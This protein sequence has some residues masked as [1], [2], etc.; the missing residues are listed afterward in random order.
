LEDSEAAVLLTQERLKRLL[1]PCEAKVI[2]LDTD[3]EAI[4]KQSEKNPPGQATSENIAYVIYTSG[5]T[6]KPK[7]VLVQHNSLINYTENICAEFAVGP[8]DRALQFASIAFDAAAE[9]IYPSLTRGATL[10]LR[11]DAMI[12]SAPVF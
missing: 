1:P 3:W 6:G 8:G 10:V 11:S 2:S 4:D 12:S 5:S 7:G 9:E